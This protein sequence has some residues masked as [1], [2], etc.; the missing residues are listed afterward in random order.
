[1]SEEKHENSTEMSQPIIIDLGKQKS[2]A[3]KKLKK[4]EGKLWD[5]VFDVVEEV[6]ELLEE[7]TEGK[8]LI[9]IIML[10]QKKSKQQRINFERMLFPF[11]DDRK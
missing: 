6:K 8:I 1:M 10:Y 7:D 2:G 5:E 11:L 4:G 9:P 3:I